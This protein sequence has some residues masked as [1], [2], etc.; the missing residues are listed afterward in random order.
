MLYCLS[1]LMQALAFLHDSGI[2]HGDVKPVGVPV[3]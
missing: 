3:T 2:A 1:A